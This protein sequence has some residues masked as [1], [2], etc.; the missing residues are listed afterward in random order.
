MNFFE[1]AGALLLLAILAAGFLLK[2]YTKR[3]LKDMEGMS[4]IF[5]KEDGNITASF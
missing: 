3:K 5:K 2:I 1:I 4:G